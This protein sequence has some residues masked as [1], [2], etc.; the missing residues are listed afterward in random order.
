M[1]SPHSIFL[2]FD[3]LYENM[4]LDKV[5]RFILVS[6]QDSILRMVRLPESPV[7]TPR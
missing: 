4:E 3:V 1:P 7:V 6:V 2:S 5:P